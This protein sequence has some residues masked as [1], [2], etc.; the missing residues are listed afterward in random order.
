MIG[1]R[2]RAV[3][4]RGMSRRIPGGGEGGGTGKRQ[5]KEGVSGSTRSDKGE[6]GLRVNRG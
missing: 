5:G 3:P 6:R 1:R 4:D 2:C